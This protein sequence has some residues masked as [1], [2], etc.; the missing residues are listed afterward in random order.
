MRHY[1]YFWHL[2][3]FPTTQF[4][5]QF[6]ASV[7]VCVCG[8]GAWF[9]V[10]SFLWHTCAIGLNTQWEKVYMFWMFGIIIEDSMKS[11]WCITMESIFAWNSFLSWATLDFGTVTFVQAEN[12][13]DQV[14]IKQPVLHSDFNWCREKSQTVPKR[15]KVWFL[16]I[17]VQM[18]S[19]LDVFFAGNLQSPSSTATVCAEIV[20]S[21]AS[22]P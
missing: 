13:N 20:G 21:P 12:M 5:K 10:R 4:E 1:W 16:W 6:Q 22:T 3:C 2:R 9:V 14:C 7:S 11:C 18:L 19:R 15:N 8:V 17:K